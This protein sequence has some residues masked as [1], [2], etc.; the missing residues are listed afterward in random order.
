[1]MLKYSIP[2]SK[3]RIGK[4]EWCSMERYNSTYIQTLIEIGKL[5]S[6]TL[7]SLLETGS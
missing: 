1:M 7:M 2:T 4:I 5:I 3:V 6:V